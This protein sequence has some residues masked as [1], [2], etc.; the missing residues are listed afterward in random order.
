MKHL[1]F[2][3]SLTPKAVVPV[4]GEIL[5]NS[6]IP[7]VLVGDAM[8]GI[9]GAL[10]FPRCLQFVV[11]DEHLDAAID[12]LVAAG[13]PRCDD[14]NGCR[15]YSTH[16]PLAAAHFHLW[17]NEEAGT[18]D[19]GKLCVFQKSDMLWSFPDFPYY[20]TD[21]NDHYFMTITDNRLPDQPA[22]EGLFGRYAVDTYP[23]RIPVPIKACEAAMLLYCRDQELKL[24][25]AAWEVWL[26]M[27]A[28]YVWPTDL[29][30]IGLRV[31]RDGRVEH[32]YSGYWDEVGSQNRSWPEHL[33]KLGYK[34]LENNGIPISPGRPGEKEKKEKEDIPELFVPLVEKYS[35]LERF[36]M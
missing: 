36:I 20:V 13:F 25:N 1:I 9:M 27:L 34:V 23:V 3:R 15:R 32:P 16:F 17:D 18:Q 22:E 4:V 24:N 35:A 19:P 33:R 7:N 8:L 21:K 28:E 5:D 29:Y 11:P 10:I 12:V 2:N 30:Q 14:S 26:L 31:D 6:L